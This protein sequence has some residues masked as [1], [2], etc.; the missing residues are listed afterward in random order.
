[1]RQIPKANIDKIRKD[2]MTSPPIRFV[3][4][5]LSAVLSGIVVQG[6]LNPGHLYPGGLSGVTLLIQRIGKKYMDVYIPYGTMNIA[7]NL[8]PIYIGFKYLGKKF[9]AYSCFNIV[10]ASIF[11]DVMP[12]I[13]ITTDPLLLS[14][15]GGI[16]YGLVSALC[17]WV[18]AT[19][20]GTDF[21]SIFLSSQKGIDAWN[22]ILGFNVVLL[23]IAG[24]IFGW[25]SALYS[26]IFQFAFTQTLHAT[27]HKYQQQTLFIITKYPEEVCAAIYEVSNHGATILDG[28]GSYKKTELEVIYSI[29]SRGDVPKIMKVVHLIDADAF[30]NSIRT[31]QVKGYF[32]QKPTE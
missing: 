2:K 18:D 17:L 12:R 11:A 14:V 23:V 21:I 28:K 29:V 9:T 25:K 4:L 24:L 6:F 5:T 10:L 20:G 31:E 32:Y 16:L 19:A 1:M 30:V 13:T 3:L 26:I 27:Y 8:V 15:F 22:T 7:L